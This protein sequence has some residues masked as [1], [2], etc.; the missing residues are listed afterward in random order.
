VMSNY[1]DK[2]MGGSPADK[3]ENYVALS[4]FLASEAAGGNAKRLKDI[5]IRLYTE[6]DIDLV[7]NRYCKELMLADL[8]VTDLEKLQQVLKESG[9]GN[10][11]LIVTKDRGYHS[12]NIAEPRDLASWIARLGKL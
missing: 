8:N 1:L 9:N 5:P 2:V 11:E 10:C 6:P 12:W 3:R 7:K 4:P